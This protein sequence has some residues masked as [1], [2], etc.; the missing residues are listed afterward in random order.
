[1]RLL[2]TKL[3]PIMLL[4]SRA[5]CLT[6]ILCFQNPRGVSGYLSS[7]RQHAFRQELGNHVSDLYLASTASSDMN[8]DA[9][10][11]KGQSAISS[12]D[13]H[14][15]PKPNQPP[16]SSASGIKSKENENN[17][18]EELLDMPWSEAQA[19][20][21][22]TNLAKYSVMITLKKEDTE[23]TEL[24]GLWRTMLLEVDELAGYPI[25]FLQKMHARQREDGKTSLQTT[26]KVLPY[27]DSYEFTSMGGATGTAFGL[28]GLQDGA[29]I[30]TASVD[31]I[32]VTLPKGFIRCSDGSAAYEL[33]T[34]WREKRLSEPS[35][36]S[37]DKRS[38]LSNLKANAAPLAKDAA[39]TI[40]EDE[41]Q[42][43]AR[44]GAT[45][46][47]LLAG[48]TAINMLSHHL[49]VNVFWV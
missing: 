15:K 49:T 10:S 3:C 13:N 5:A 28:Q 22:Q 45:T 41:D 23:V 27:L 11:R 9:S 43:L 17:N 44:L 40:V 24:Y 30:E 36:I 31:N 37:T 42:L 39:N 34:P 19:W 47:I 35:S 20:A 16:S 38:L 46:G 32:Q 14:N 18:G 8:M 4:A 21:L 7:R 29:R 48:A 6:M 33:G 12:S 26:P 25:E 1:M 2:A